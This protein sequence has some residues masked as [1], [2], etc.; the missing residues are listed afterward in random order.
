MSQT[1]TVETLCYIVAKQK[2]ETGECSH[3]CSFCYTEYEDHQRRK[4]QENNCLKNL[5]T[6]CD[7]LLCKEE[8]NA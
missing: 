5:F 7:C 8:A 2:H 4:E 1:I 6:S 3:L